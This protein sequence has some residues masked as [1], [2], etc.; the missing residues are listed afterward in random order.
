VTLDRKGAGFARRP[1][2]RLELITVAHL[3]AKTAAKRRRLRREFRSEWSHTF[4]VR[5][6]AF[7]IL[8]ACA[9]LRRER[10]LHLT[11]GEPRTAKACV[12]D[13]RRFLRTAQLHRAQIAAFLPL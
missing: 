7:H 2:C 8:N 3:T 10:A 12:Y 6:R 4:H 13:A 9:E 5:D 11:Q 1:F